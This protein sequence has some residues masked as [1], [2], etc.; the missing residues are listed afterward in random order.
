MAVE[1]SHGMVSFIAFLTG[2]LQ[3]KDEALLPKKKK[4][5]ENFNT[6]DFDWM[7]QWNDTM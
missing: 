3:N 6:N 5:G 1:S 4:V 7:T 2:Q